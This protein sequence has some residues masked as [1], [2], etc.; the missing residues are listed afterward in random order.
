MVIIDKNPFDAIKMIK[1]KFLDYTSN[2]KL[3]TNNWNNS[4][5]DGEI[6]ETI[7]W[8][9]KDT[10][11]NYIKNGNKDYGTE[12]IDYEMNEYSFRT[13]SETNNIKKKNTIACFGCSQT[14]GAGLPWNETWPSILNKFIGNEWDVRNYG[15]CG[16]SNDMISRCI[17]NY[18]IKY[19][20]SYICVFFPETLR[21]ELFSQNKN[22]FDNFLPTEIDQIKKYNLEKWKY[23]RAYREIANEENGMYNFIKNFKF[24]DMLCKTKNIPWFWSTWAHSVFFSKDNFKQDFLRLDNYIKDLEDIESYL[25]VARDGRHFGKNTCK[26]IAEAFH[27]KIK[28]SESIVK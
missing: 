1:E 14:F 25:D 15:Y 11:E 7:K 17:H 21:M 28:S 18:T 24:I 8:F 2:D 19:N 27:N 6:I 16:A 13:S 12:D 22:D 26:K 9:G 3:F 5:F 10:Y 23:Y 20:P 4:N